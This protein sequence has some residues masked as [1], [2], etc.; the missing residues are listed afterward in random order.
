MMWPPF[1]VRIRIIEAGQK[2]ISL[3]L[4]LIIIWP[5]VAFLLLLA[6]PFFFT[7]LLVSR[8]HAIRLFIDSSKEIFL[9]FCSLRDMEVDVQDKNSEVLIK[10]K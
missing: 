1:I 9:L 10:F 6:A 2:K 4:P 8:V 7:A 5:F 3:W